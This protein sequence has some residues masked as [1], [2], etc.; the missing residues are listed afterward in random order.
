MK[1]ILAFTVLVGSSVTA[2][3]PSSNA[4]STPRYST[5]MGIAVDSVRGGFLKGASVAMLGPS[6]MGLTDSLGRFS[7]D[8]IPPGPHRVA[9]LDG[10][11][12]S[13]S[14]SVVSPPTAF[15]AGDAVTLFLAIPTQ[16]RATLT[17]GR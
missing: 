16:K 14:I 5:L 11:L 17:A 8:S 12:D 4:Q 2:Q 3:V 10:L 6:R 13:L 9:L 1:I 15:A 7:I